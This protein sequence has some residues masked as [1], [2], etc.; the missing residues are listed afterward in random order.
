MCSIQSIN[1]SSLINTIFKITKKINM[2]LK[3]AVFIALFLPLF[4]TSLYSQNNTSAERERY[5]LAQSYENSG[6]Y[7]EAGRLY[8][9][10][11]YE[12]KSNVLYFD[13]YLRAYKELHKYSELIEDVKTFIEKHPLIKYRSVMAELYW[14]IGDNQKANDEWDKI[15]A[16]NIKNPEAYETIAYDQMSLRQYDKAIAT[17]VQGRK[18]MGVKGVF[19]DQLSRYYALTG[20]FKNGIEEVLLLE[21]DPNLRGYAQSRLY[22]FLENASAVEYFDIRLKKEVEKNPNDYELYKLLLWYYRTT[23]REDKAFDMCIIIDQ[24][25]KASGREIYYF[26]DQA[27]Y[28]GEYEI[29]IK[30]YNYILNLG[31]ASPYRSTAYYGLTR[32]LE[33]RALES[34]SIKLDEMKMIVDSYLK[35]AKDFSANPQSDE[36]LLRAANLQYKYLKKTDDAVKILQNLTAKAK[37]TDIKTKASLKLGEIYLAENNLPK[38]KDEF[39]N[40]LTRYTNIDPADAS[41]AQ[42]NLAM[43]EYY[44]G[45]LDS[46]KVQF[47]I[48][49][50]DPKSQVA[51]DALEYSGFITE[52]KS[53]SDAIDIYRKAELLIQQN[54]QLEAAEKFIAV[55]ACAQKTNIGE[56]ALVNAANIYEDDKQKPKAIEIWKRLAE[57]YPQGIYCDLVYY[58]IANY[59]SETKNYDEAMKYYKKLLVVYPRSIYVED[60]R[61]KARA[62]RDEKKVTGAE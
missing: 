32:S 6:N 50:L 8:K 23:N 52:N 61:K 10:L 9:E 40:V 43:L 48:L 47:D 17:L 44:I 36:S 19:A 34:D 60:A 53:N 35:M 54:K 4:F 26:A 13:S 11:F 1:L 49:G 62:L 59:N 29:A 7:E 58:N 30:A 18:N 51:N 45:D 15:I 57:E 27:R 16:D 5:Q 24:L 31:S 38:A 42:Y 33:A 20:D 22:G 3:F 12:Q 25:R 55:A 39:R 21:A 41:Q 37:I 46:A 56:K 2:N 14:K 28:D